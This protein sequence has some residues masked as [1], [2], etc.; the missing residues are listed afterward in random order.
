M[1]AATHEAH[2]Y[3]RVTVKLNDEDRQAM[4]VLS[5][6]VRKK[7]T[8]L[9]VPFTSVVRAGMRVLAKHPALHEEFAEMLL[10]VHT[11]DKRRL[12]GPARAKGSKG[13]PPKA[14]GSAKTLK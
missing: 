8:F 5:R 7:A 14:A 1:A 4:A 6:A 10:T 3:Q 2:Q 12:R 13:R 11:A 9:N